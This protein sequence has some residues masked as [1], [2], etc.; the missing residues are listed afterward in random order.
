MTA[1]SHPIEE[2]GGWIE[3]SGGECP[4]ADD[5]TLFDVQLRA[6]ATFCNE[7]EAT[8]WRWIHSGLPGDI[9]AYRVL[10]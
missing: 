10:S 7:N 5:K 8:G 1:H 3:W 2:A 9:I 6:G 4:I